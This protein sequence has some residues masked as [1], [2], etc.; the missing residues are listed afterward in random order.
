MTTILTDRKQIPNTPMVSDVTESRHQC[1]YCNQDNNMFIANTS[2]QIEGH[3]R[4]SSNHLFVLIQKSASLTT[5][6]MAWSQSSYTN[7]FVGTFFARSA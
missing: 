2:S 4:C 6:S 7:S 3:L 5:R 1:A